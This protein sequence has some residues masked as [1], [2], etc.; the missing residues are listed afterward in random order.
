MPQSPWSVAIDSIRQLRKV[1]C[2]WQVNDPLVNGRTYG[3]RN[4]VY[5]LIW[6]NTSNR[7]PAIGQNYPVRQN[8]S[9]ASWRDVGEY[10]VNICKTNDES[11]Y[12]GRR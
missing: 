2:S 11:R 4:R 7:D 8:F 5:K 1:D 9:N 3:W 12:W 10:G 6:M